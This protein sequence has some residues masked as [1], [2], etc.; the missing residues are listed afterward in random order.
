M[1]NG[2]EALK[3]IRIWTLS[4]LYFPEETSTGHFMTKITERLSSNFDTNVICA[5]PT[6]SMRGITTSK[7][8]TYNNVKIRRVFSTTFN[9]DIFFLKLLNILTFGVS[10]LLKGLIQIKRNDVIFVVTNPPF[11]PIIA[12]IISKIKR[13]R[14]ILRIDDVYPDI[15]VVAN[16]ISEHGIFFH[17]F[18]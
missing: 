5:Q 13:A 7:N 9:K 4:E 15:L 8:E 16:K 14:Y 2:S 3:E 1:K 17:F 10:T 6:Y 12:L 18:S 11:L